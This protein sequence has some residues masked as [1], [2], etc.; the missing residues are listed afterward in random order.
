ID[1]NT[2]R[3]PELAVAI[4]PNSPVRDKRAGCVE[5]LDAVIIS[6]CD[7][8]VPFVINCNTIWP[9]EQAILISPV[10]P[11]EVEDVGFSCCGCDTWYGTQYQCGHQNEHNVFPHVLSPK[12]PTLPEGHRDLT[13]GNWMMLPL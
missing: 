1:R 6:I 4:S 13:R 12:H 11:L 10:S 3:A 2:N 9:F 7:V 5:F 8:N